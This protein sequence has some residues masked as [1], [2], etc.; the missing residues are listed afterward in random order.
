MSRKF[1][2][3]FFLQY[4]NPPWPPLRRLRL[5]ERRA[6]SWLVL[7]RLYVRLGRFL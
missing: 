6:R 3:A 4:P 2:A 1:F 7:G 5:P